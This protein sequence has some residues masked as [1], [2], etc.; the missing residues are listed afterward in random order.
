M[1]AKDL[2]ENYTA[3]LIAIKY[4]TSRKRAFEMLD[5]VCEGKNIKISEEDFENMLEIKEEFNMSIS[6]TMKYFNISTTSYYR[7]LEKIQGGI[8]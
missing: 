4:N 2:L 1:H 6:A 8:S 3:L 7:N 5:R